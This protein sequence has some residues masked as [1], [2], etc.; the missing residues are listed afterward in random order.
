MVDPRAS[1]CVEASVA[2][3]EAGS[4]LSPGDR[5]CPRQ[6]PTVFVVEDDRETRTSLA[7]LVSSMGLPVETF[8][9]GEEFL[10]GL[11]IARPGCV[12][13]DFRLRGMDGVTLHKELVDVGSILPVILISADWDVRTAAS[14]LQDGVFRVLEKPYHEDELAR[15]IQDALEWDRTLRERL[16]CRKEI[17][18]RLKSLD[19][20]EH[21]V[22]ELILTGQPNKAIERRLRLSRRTVER[23]RSA[24]LNKMG[25]L[26]FVELSSA[27]AMAT[28]GGDKDSRLPR[29]EA[30]S[31]A[32]I[33]PSADRIR[34]TLGESPARYE[35]DGRLLRYDLHDGAAQYVSAAILRLQSLDAQPGIP[36]DA[37]ATLREAMTLLS[38]TIR[39]RGRRQ[40][41]PFAGAP[42]EMG[43]WPCDEGP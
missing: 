5:E 20:R 33:S 39:D 36:A 2:S 6:S 40:E 32:L 35:R 18:N 25:T 14:A 29:N 10:E 21:L 8:A 11:D 7:A 19:V 41:M 26:S 17:E 43:G 12:L 15:A 38:M 16:R 37:K 42:G 24:I 30:R 31:L 4:H 3:F 22:L 23:I 34:A 13:G 1:D 27:I 28:D 9:S